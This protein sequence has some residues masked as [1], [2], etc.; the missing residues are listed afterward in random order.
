MHNTINKAELTRKDS[1]RNSYQKMDKAFT[2]SK[3][4]LA[5]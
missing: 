2:D 4:L 3:W 5:L 1:H